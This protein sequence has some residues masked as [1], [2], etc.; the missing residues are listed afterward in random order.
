M[1][2]PLLMGALY[3]VDVALPFY[4]TAGCCAL[5]C[6]VLLKWPQLRRKR[7]LEQDA[8]ETR[9]MVMI[10]V[11]ARQGSLSTAF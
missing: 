4:A 3:G 5:A 7:K 8:D 9:E 6:L 10:E 11:L 1:N 2:S